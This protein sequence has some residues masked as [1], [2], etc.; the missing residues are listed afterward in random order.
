[1]AE[2]KIECTTAWL[3]LQ[4]TSDVAQGAPQQAPS[5]LP[6]VSSRLILFPQHYRCQQLVT[7]VTKNTCS[8]KHRRGKLGTGSTHFM[9]PP[10]VACVLLPASGVGGAAAARWNFA[11]F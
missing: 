7:R 1:M 8:N 4:I 2:S 11:R 10:S 9:S 3:A 5:A 6:L